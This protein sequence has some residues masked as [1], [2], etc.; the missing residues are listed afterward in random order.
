MENSKQNR[1]KLAEMLVARLTNKQIKHMLIN[2]LAQDL[3]NNVLF[4]E[5]IMKIRKLYGEIK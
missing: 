4:E 5:T 3:T 1:F 2:V